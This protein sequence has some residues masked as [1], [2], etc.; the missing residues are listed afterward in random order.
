MKTLTT[1]EK[2]FAYR[3]A[4]SQSEPKRSRMLNKFLKRVL[5]PHLFT[6]PQREQQISSLLKSAWTAKYKNSPTYKRNNQIT[7]KRNFFRRKEKC[8]QDINWVMAQIDCNTFSGVI[9]SPTTHLNSK[10]GYYQSSIWGKTYLVHRM[11]Y[12]CHH[13]TFIPENLEINHIDGDKK[14][15]RIDNL[16]LVDHKLNLLLFHGGPLGILKKTKKLEQIWD[17]LAF[18]YAQPYH[19]KIRNTIAEYGVSAPTLNCWAQIFPKH[20]FFN[21][22]KAFWVSEALRKQGNR[23]GK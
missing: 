16:E 13:K 23:V 20:C 8:H 17:V 5:P 7:N 9:S 19:D 15:N 4:M 12:M 22:D 1:W 14:N 6:D 11:I 10:T 3:N 18:Y 21:K 2:N